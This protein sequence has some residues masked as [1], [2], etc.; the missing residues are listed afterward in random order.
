MTHPINTNPPPPTAEERAMLRELAE[1]DHEPWDIDDRRC[2][3]CDDPIHLLDGME[4]IGLCNNCRQELSGS[5]THVLDA[6]DTAE[7]ERDDEQRLR[8]VLDAARDAAE[9]YVE[10]LEAEVAAAKDE[11]G[12]L[13]DGVDKY[14]ADLARVTGELAE[15][16]ANTS[17]RRVRAYFDLEDLA[18]KLRT[19]YEHFETT[20]RKDIRSMEEQDRWMAVARAADEASADLEEAKRDASEGRSLLMSELAQKRVL[21]DA[22]A[23]SQRDREKLQGE[24]DAARNALRAILSGDIATSQTQAVAKHALGESMT[25][26]E[27][28]DAQCCYHDADR[29]VVTIPE[30]LK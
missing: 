7:R 2:P 22:L 6:L 24:R 17:A 14:K 19:A 10:K 23:I 20:G 12:I 1:A 13:R 15:A 21:I 16:N 5:M 11:L 3:G 29:S 25:L 18:T 9:R 30:D 26:S 8:R 28:D 27:M 4:P